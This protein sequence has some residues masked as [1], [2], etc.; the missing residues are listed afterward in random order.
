PSCNAMIT[1]AL[2]FVFGA[3]VLQHQS[4]LPPLYRALALIP[5]VPLAYGLHK[6]PQLRLLNNCLQG[7]LFFL[8]GCMWAAWFAHLRMSDDLPREWES[9]NIQIIGVVASLPQQLERGKRFEFDV[10]QVLTPEAVVPEHISLTHY[11]G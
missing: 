8:A 7:L 1:L 3:W 10:E 6:S 11:S 4:A 9:Q 5:L 2:A